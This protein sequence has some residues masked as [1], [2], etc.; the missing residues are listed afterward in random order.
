MT[1]DTTDPTVCQMAGFT[2][3]IGGRWKLGILCTL[4]TDGKARF[5][6]LV[7]RLAPITPTTLTRQLRE[8]ERDGLVTRTQYNEIPPRV[9]YEATELSATL[10]PVLETI[11]EWVHTHAL[12]R[13]TLTEPAANEVRQPA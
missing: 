11:A 1:D 8:L 12:Q 5:N 7:E 4:T 3:V 2:S 9:E 6:E 13:P 10:G